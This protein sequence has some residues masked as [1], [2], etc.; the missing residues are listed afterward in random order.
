ML[1]KSLSLDFHFSSLVPII[2]KIQLAD[3][4]LDIGLV[5]EKEI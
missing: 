4:D 5:E 2:G 3:D 1:N